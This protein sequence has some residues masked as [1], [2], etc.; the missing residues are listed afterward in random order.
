MQDVFDKY[1][2]Q[3]SESLSILPDKDEESPHNTLKALWLAASGSPVSVLKAESCELSELSDDDIVELEDLIEKR[4]NN[5]PL[6]HLT[7]RQLFMGME[8]LAGP[9]ALIPRKETEI[10][11]RAAIELL[12][13]ISGSVDFPRVVDVCTGAGNIALAMADADKNARVFAADLS[14]DAVGLARKNADFLGLSSQVEFFCGDLLAPLDD[15]GLY[16]KVHLLT[17]NPPYISTAKVSDMP[18]EISEHEPSMAFDGGA[19]GVNLIRTLIADAERFLCKNG[20]LLFEVGLG[21]GNLIRKQVEKAGAY[22]N[23]KTLNDDAGNPR[24]VMAQK[25]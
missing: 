2:A 17:C 5:V 19:F 10:L 8:M 4:L 3:L 18:E 12:L 15:A 25:I 1:L 7:G 14:E 21:Q 11:G 20:Y 22:K 6:A 16:E 24:V 23:I 13:E 9:E